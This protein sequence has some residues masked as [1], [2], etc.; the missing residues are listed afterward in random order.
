MAQ[1]DDFMQDLLK[2]GDDIARSVNRAFESGDYSDLNSQITRSVEQAKRSTQSRFQQPPHEPG[3]SP[4]SKPQRG[5][6]PPNGGQVPPPPQHQ[7]TRRT[8][9]RAPGMGNP[10]YTQTSHVTYT[11]NTSR[12]SKNNFQMTP[13]VQTEVKQSSGNNRMIGGAIGAVIFGMSAIEELSGLLMYGMYGG[14]VADF[15]I[16]GVIFAVCAGLFIKGRNER[17]LARE[18]QKYANIVGNRTYIE[19]ADLARISEE[20]P[21]IVLSNL[22]KMMQ[23]GL[24]PQAMLDDAETTLMLTK[25]VYDA[26]IQNKESQ[27]VKEAEEREKQKEEANLTEEEKNVRGIIEEGNLYI[28]KI[29]DAND[30]IP[31]DVMSEKLDRLETIM[32]RI[33]EQVKEHPETAGNLRKLMDYYLPTI[34]KLLNAYISLDQQTIEGNNIKQTKK[35][36]EEVLDTVNDAFE[37][38]LDSMFNDM[39]WDIS[40]D[41]SVMQTMLKQDGLSGE[42]ITGKK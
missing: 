9:Y 13:F 29:H 31:D 18:F 34:E 36:I 16:S 5:Y 12:T 32:R 28:Q 35:Q 8:P 25:D 27:K 17:N 2:A 21:K 30:A 42:S 1:Q 4:Y 33:F 41:I 24:L 3:R 20:S 15:A 23:K 14:D 26:Y 39:A 22:K 38:L 40:S 7:Q 6:R 10:G 11:S 19:I 37:N